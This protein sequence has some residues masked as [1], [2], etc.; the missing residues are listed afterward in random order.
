MPEKPLVIA[1]T[2]DVERAPENTLPAFES[3]VERGAD[4]VELDVHLSRD[5]HLVVHHFNNLGSSDNGSGLVCEHSLAELKA[6]DSGSWFDRRFAGE[7]KPTLRD[8]LGRFRGR[9]RF[10]IDLKDTGA[11]FLRQVTAQVEE[12]DLAGAVELTSAHCPLL[13]LAKKLDPALRT[14][15]FF[16]APPGWMPVRLAQ[17]HTL[18]WAEMLEIAAVHLNLALITA[19]FVEQLHQAGFLVA[20]SNLDTAEQIRCDLAAGIDSFST[21][22]LGIALPL[23]D[24]F[25]ARGA[26][27]WNL[28][29]FPNTA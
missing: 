3:A 12:Y 27:G 25:C 2:G 11:A 18:D 19:E 4:G 16:Y 20:G 9:T 26:A 5:G 8:V 10:E 23:R 22:R 28:D 29:T 21:G 15:T 14:G 24:E 7:P 17:K 1:R 13:K 6:L